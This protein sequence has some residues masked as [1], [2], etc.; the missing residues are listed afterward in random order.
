MRCFENGLVTAPSLVSI[1]GRS[2][3]ECVQWPDVGEGNRRIRNGPLCV[4]IEIDVDRSEA[5]ARA[6][7]C[8]VDALVGCYWQTSADLL[9]SDRY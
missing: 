7:R 1:E 4:R 3:G 2:A 5:R 8:F 9:S 6:T